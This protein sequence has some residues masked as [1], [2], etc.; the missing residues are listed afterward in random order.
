[1]LAK[2]YQ[3]VG[4]ATIVGQ[5]TGGNL[6]GINGGGI[7][8][9]TL[10]NTQIETDIPIFKYL[11]TGISASELSSIPNQGVIPDMLIDVQVTDIQQQ[12]EWCPR[13]FDPYHHTG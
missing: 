7:F 5:P 8:F 6:R 3:D 13:Y 4:L 10:P 2:Q 9:L 1:M 11:P 12:T